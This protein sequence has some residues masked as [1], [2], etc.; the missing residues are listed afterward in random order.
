MS[1]AL[2]FNRLTGADPNEDRSRYML[3]IDGVGGYLVCLGS[4]VTIGGPA[5]DKDCDVSLLANLSRCHATIVR[6]GEGYLLQA[7]APCS[8]GGRPVHESALLHHGYEIELGTGVRLKFCLP[9]VLSATATLQFV[10]NHRPAQS[11]DGIVLM[12]DNCLLGPGHETHIRCRRWQDTVVL[13]RRDGQF[14]CKSRMDLFVN[15]RLIKGESAVG[16]QEVVTGPDFRFRIEP[17]TSGKR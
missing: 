8:V 16:T 5:D 13:F 3:W 4:R 1:A 15:S 10:S 6:S 9:T 12:E 14:W 2:T 17:I 11:V 7:H